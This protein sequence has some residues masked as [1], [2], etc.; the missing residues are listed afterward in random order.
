[1]CQFCQY[2]YRINMPESLFF[3]FSTATIG[4]WCF[5]CRAKRAEDWSCSVCLRKVCRPSQQPVELARDRQTYIGLRPS[6][7]VRRTDASSRCLS[8]TLVK[9][10]PGNIGIARGCTEWPVQLPRTEKNLGAKFTGESCKCTPR[11]SVHP[12]T[13]QESNF[14]GSG[15]FS[16]RPT[17]THF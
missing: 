13:E 6:L 3:I 16:S 7:I 11:H 9:S 8:A 12:Q 10:Q 2:I 5:A 14:L 17:S 1:M 15:E 4:I